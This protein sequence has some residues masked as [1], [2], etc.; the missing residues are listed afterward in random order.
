MN[1][2]TANRARLRAA[3]ARI[4][5]RRPDSDPA[6]ARFRTAF[7]SARQRIRAHVLDEFRKYDWP[8]LKI[9]DDIFEKRLGLPVPTLSVCGAGTAEVRFTKLLA[10][11]FDS[12]NHHGLGDLLVHAVFAEKINDGTHLSFESCTAQAE[13]PLGGACLPDGQEMQNV[14]DVLIDVGGHKIAV[15]HKINSAEGEDQL[16][17]YFAALTKK[18]PGAPLSCF[19]LTPDG[20]DVS[21]QNRKNWKPLSHRDLFLRM[22]SLLDRHALSATAR[23]NLRAFLWDLMLGPMA[24]DRKWMDE[25]AVQVHHVAQD[26]R[27]YTGLKKW[28]QRDDLG[29]DELRMLLRIVGDQA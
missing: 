11:F 15:E 20:R 24:Q 12:R 22:A 23:H 8:R 6:V 3:I 26:Y 7:N 4:K 16:G 2:T 13:V 25:F 21:E 5:E 17:R 9:L 27:N 18:F 10:H 19:Y 28:L 29:L 1:E 14:L